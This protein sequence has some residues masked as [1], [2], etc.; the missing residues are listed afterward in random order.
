M[1]AVAFS[2]RQ[3][4]EEAHREVVGLADRVDKPANLGHPRLDA[5]KR[6]AC[7]RQLGVAGRSLDGTVYT[8]TTQPVGASRVDDGV[9]CEVW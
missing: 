2:L 3:A 6:L 5:A 4:A 9:D 7:S 1:L 8:A